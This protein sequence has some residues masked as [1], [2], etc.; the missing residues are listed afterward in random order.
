MPLKRISIEKLPENQG[1]MKLGPKFYNRLTRVLRMKP[2]DKLILFD[3]TGREAQA[4]II[5]ED[6]NGITVQFN[7]PVFADREPACDITLAF[8]MP[9]GHKPDL[10]IQKGTELGVRKF[11]LFNAERSISRLSGK[12]IDSKLN[13][14]NEIIKAATEQCGRVFFPKLTYFPNLITL[15]P[16]INEKMRLCFKPDANNKMSAIVERKPDSVAL[17][18]GPEGGLTTQESDQAKKQG[19]IPVTFG[20]RI[21]RL[22]TA[23]IAAVVPFSLD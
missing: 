2:V 21:L 12:R 20:K 14:W 9:K 18:I 7:K 13:R 1:T 23:A 17:L 3:S 4:Q 8:A 16:V 6:S 11:L 10:I 5:D 15:L 19:F 22:E